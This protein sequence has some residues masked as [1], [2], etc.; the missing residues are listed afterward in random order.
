VDRVDDKDVVPH[1]PRVVSSASIRFELCM[2]RERLF[3]V[4][5]PEGSL[6]TERLGSRTVT[7]GATE[8]AAAK[9]PAAKTAP[10]AKKPAP[11]AKAKGPA[12]KGKK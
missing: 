1:S 4:G 10:A 6:I 3:T 12:K 8:M 2:S 9:K 5:Y 7:E 11:S